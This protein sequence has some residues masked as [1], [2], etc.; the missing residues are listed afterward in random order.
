MS[1]HIYIA[2]HYY[3]GKKRMNISEELYHYVVN[4]TVNGFI[5]P[6]KTTLL[7]KQKTSQFVFKIIHR[8]A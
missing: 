1:T 7:S 5:D 4:S 8:Y 6:V 2:F 3:E